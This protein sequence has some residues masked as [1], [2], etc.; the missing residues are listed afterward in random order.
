MGWL[1][2]VDATG[3]AGVI[4]AFTA[5]LTFVVG[6]R[7][8]RAGRKDTARIQEASDEFKRERLESEERHH[9]NAVKDRLI[10]QLNIQL[11]RETHRADRE[12]EA[13]EKH[14]HRA[15]DAEQ[16]IRELRNDVHD[17]AAALKAEALDAAKPDGVIPAD[18]PVEPDV[19]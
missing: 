9:D 11:D 12:R 13:G 19:P 10:E 6:V 17:L 15:E 3:I 2:D 4:V 14:Y 1:T 18:F 16:K 7:Q 8:T 5:L